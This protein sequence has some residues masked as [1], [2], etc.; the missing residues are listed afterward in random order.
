M[1]TIRLIVSI[2]LALPLGALIARISAAFIRERP[3]FQPTEVPRVSPRTLA[4]VVATLIVFLLA[5]I[6]FNEAGWGEF[7]AYLLGF[8]VLLLASVI[9]ITEYRLPDVVV[10]PALAVGLVLVTTISVAESSSDRIRFAFFGALLAFAVLLIA[11]LIS[12]QGMGFGDVK[13]ASLLG[14][15]VGWQADSIAEVLLLVLWLFLIGFAIGTVGGL[16]FMVL[17]GRNQPFPFGPF[18]ALGTLITVVFSQSLVG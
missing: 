17:R 14:L 11:H 9:D 16:A 4:I 2:A 18:L 5:A 1:D 8:A 15:M 3:V 13:F 6:R 10:V 12:P 7:L